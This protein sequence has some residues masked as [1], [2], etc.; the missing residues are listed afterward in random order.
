[1]LRVLVD[2]EDAGARRQARE[3]HRVLGIEQDLDVVV[4]IVDAEHEPLRRR[5]ER[6]RQPEHEL[7][8]QAAVIDAGLEV[9]DTIE[10][11]P[12]AV[13]AQVSEVAVLFEVR[14]GGVAHRLD[15]GTLEPAVPVGIVLVDHDRAEELVELPAMPHADQLPVLEDEAGDVG[16]PDVRMGTRLVREAAAS[17]ECEQGYKAKTGSPTQPHPPE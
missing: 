14:E 10:G 6:L 2:V 3:A 15:L 7:V 8:H 5:I 11:D 1:M 4:L 13:G 12:G 16:D 17:Q 9:H